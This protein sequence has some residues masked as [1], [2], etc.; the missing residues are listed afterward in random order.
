VPGC[1][2]NDAGRA[3]GREAAHMSPHAGGSGRAGS[4]ARLVRGP[5]DV[6]AGILVVVLGALVLAALSRM[7]VAAYTS[8]SPS[9]FPRV[10]TYALMAGGAALILRGLLRDGP[11]LER[12]RLW[13]LA[14]VTLA[15]V[16][17]GMVAPLAGYAVA[18][19]LTLVIGGLAAPDLRLR[20]L[21]VMSL[22]LVAFS[23]ALFS[24][25]LKLT[26]PILVLPGFSI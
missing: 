3:T 20:E 21:I 14:L 19:L 6:L 23:V 9:L 15:I 2:R 17:F 18:G 5:Q 12:L 11:G 8:V 10:C 22:C 26:M 24:W 16:L 25:A 13:P 7:R 4:R 1:R